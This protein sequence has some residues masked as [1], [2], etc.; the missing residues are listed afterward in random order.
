MYRWRISPN[1]F[2]LSVHRIR[3]T[4]FRGVIM[5]IR[6][7]IS[8][9]LDYLRKARR[10]LHAIPEKIIRNLKHRHIYCLNWNC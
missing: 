7:E 5:Q 2:D 3:Y 6:P 9:N 10:T 8:E 4:V 1:K